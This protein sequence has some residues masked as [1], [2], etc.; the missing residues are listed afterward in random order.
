MSLE[1]YKEELLD[2]ARHPRNGGALAAA[3]NHAHRANPLC[4]DE[5]DFALI[6]DDEQRVT[7]VRFTGRGCTVSQA[8]AS[9]LSERLKGMT[10]TDVRKL[11]STDMITILGVPINPSRMTCATLGLQTVQQAIAEHR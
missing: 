6:I 10:V 3:T 11:T 7:D 4:G 5:V 1:M 2:H 9:M 8:A